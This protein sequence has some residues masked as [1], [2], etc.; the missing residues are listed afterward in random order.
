M[1]ITQNDL[2]CRRVS[3]YLINV[4]TQKMEIAMQML[5]FPFSVSDAYKGS[6][7]LAEPFSV[8]WVIEVI[9]YMGGTCTVSEVRDRLRAA[10]QNKSRTAKAFE[11]AFNAGKIQ[12]NLVNAGQRG[13]PRYE[14][15]ISKK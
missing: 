4:K 10:K 3:V 5:E 8:E 7:I 12:C 15:S 13:R 2:T 9:N 6:P 14:F 1:H 11:S